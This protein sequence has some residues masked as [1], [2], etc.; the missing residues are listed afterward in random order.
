MEHR[1]SATTAATEQ[2]D[3]ADV[4]GEWR[5]WELPDA[6]ELDPV[7]HGYRHRVLPIL[8]ALPTRAWRLVRR[9]TTDTTPDPDYD[10]TWIDTDPGPDEQAV[11]LL[12]RRLK[13]PRGA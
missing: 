3:D 8:V 9:S 10:G 13:R 6:P 4:V 12:L 1:L 2:A 5:G 7:E 11:Q